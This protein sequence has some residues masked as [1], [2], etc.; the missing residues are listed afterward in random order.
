MRR[1]SGAEPPVVGL[2]PQTTDITDN[3]KTDTM[4]TYILR[5]AKTVEEF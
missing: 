5:G 2:T 4:K 1:V 3:R